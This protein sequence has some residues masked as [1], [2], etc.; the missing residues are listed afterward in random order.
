MKQDAV[1][2]G[3]GGLPETRSENPSSVRIRT[4]LQVTRGVI[5]GNAKCPTAFVWTEEESV[6]PA[7]ELLIRATRDGKWLWQDGNAADLNQLFPGRKDV[8]RLI[9]PFEDWLKYYRR[10]WIRS[11]PGDFTG[12]V[13]M[14]KEWH[15]PGAFRRC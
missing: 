10:S 2:R 8:H 7:M 12:A 6:V 13:S 9:P 4:G 5:V 11:S 15:W 1:R 14:R 3:L